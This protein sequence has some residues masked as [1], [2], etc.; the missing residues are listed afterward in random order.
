MSMSDLTIKPFEPRNILTLSAREPDKSIAD[1]IDTMKM[2]KEYA[3]HGPC[4]TGYAGDT[5]I[6]CCGI[7]ILWPG[8]GEGW[9]YTSDLVP[10]FRF[11]FHRAVKRGIEQTAIGYKL[12]RLQMSIPH[13][14]I[15]SQNWI[16][17]LG[18][19]EESKMPQYGP[20]GELYIRYVKFFPCP[21]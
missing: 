3:T 18:F 7:I 4:W 1:G 6:F 8:V 9:A 2:A 10:Y 14:H 20:K 12:R 11:A 17:H 5:P 16:K 15:V 21:S 13:D 19:Q